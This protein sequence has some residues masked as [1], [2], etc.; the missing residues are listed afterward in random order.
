MEQTHW[1]HK[2]SHQ[3]SSTILCLFYVCMY[4]HILYITSQLNKCEYLGENTE[5]AP[6]NYWVQRRGL[7]YCQNTSNCADAEA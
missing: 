5:A 2:T 3:K 4:V 6:A 7:C 1:S